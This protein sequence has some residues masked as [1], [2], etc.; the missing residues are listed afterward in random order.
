MTQFYS[1][2]A[3]KYSDSRG[4]IHGRSK[5][6]E[7]RSAVGPRVPC[8]PIGASPGRARIP[9]SCRGRRQEALIPRKGVTPGRAARQSKTA[10]SAPAIN[11]KWIASHQ[12]AIDKVAARRRER[13]N[14]RS[15]AQCLARCPPWAGGPCGGRRVGRPPPLALPLVGITRVLPTPLEDI[16]TAASH[17]DNGL[18]S[19]EVHGSSPVPALVRAMRCARGHRVFRT[20]K[21]HPPRSEPHPAVGDGA[22]SAPR[23]EFFFFL[24]RANR[25]HRSAIE[26]PGYTP[27]KN[28]IVWPGLRPPRVLR[29]RAGKYTSD[30]KPVGGP[31]S[32]LAS[33]E[34]LSK[35]S[36]PI[37]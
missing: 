18:E 6:P 32:S 23:L 27:A 21:G 25:G 9:S 1:I 2:C 13:P 4:P 30:K 35:K 14:N 24:R 8:F 33:Y 22:A 19:Q 10:P 37:P 3:R 5:G 34:K 12:P 26:A 7:P 20:L 28:V 17:A 11:R 36:T 29:Q 31:T 15:F 16:S